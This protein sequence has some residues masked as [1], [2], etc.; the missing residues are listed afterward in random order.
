MPQAWYFAGSLD[1][2][3]KQPMSVTVGGREY[4]A[5]VT[6]SGIPAVLDGRCVHMG[7]NLARGCVVGEHLQCPF[8]S[9]EFDRGGICRA[10]PASASVPAFAKQR[11]YPTAVHN[12]LVFFFNGPEARFELPV[13]ERKA[14]STLLRSKSFG[15]D[16][17]LPWYMVAA[18]GFDLQHFRTA[19]D[20][21]L[22]EEPQLSSP[23]PYCRQISARFRVAG[24]GFR[25]RLTRLVS[26]DEVVMTIQSWCGALILVTASF[27]RT[28]SYGMVCVRPIAD[29]RTHI[30][31][32]VSIDRRRNWLAR[33]ILD[34]LDVAIRR[35]FIRAFMKDD[36][37][38]C[39]GIGYSK[40]TLIEADG[41][42]GD[43]LEWVRSLASMT[44]PEVR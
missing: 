2:V 3:A 12:G 41:V 34:P 10:I 38:R 36:V 9:W 28:T 40:G 21:T 14:D 6:G 26:G 44:Q 19:H 4:V 16:L 25:D 29:D 33:Q 5:Y 43:Y 13:F 27:R 8:H 15:F 17:Q 31:T 11:A 7:A 18:N 24:S 42:L 35:S 37:D 22:I 20:R 39:V 1:S 32:F 30:T 23:S